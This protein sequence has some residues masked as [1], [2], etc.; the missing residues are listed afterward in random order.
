MARYAIQTYVRASEWEIGAVMIVTRAFPV[1]GGVALQAF[2][3]ESGLC[4]I[5][6]VC[7]L[8]IGLMARP[9]IGRSALKLPVD[10]AQGTVNR[11]VCTGQR[12]LGLGVIEA[13]RCPRC[14]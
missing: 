6:I 3:A 10:V 5:G 13:G 11:D 12:E 9:T 14:R 8:V 4:V 7:A 2:V 1:V